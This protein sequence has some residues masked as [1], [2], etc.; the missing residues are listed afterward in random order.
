MIRRENHTLIFNVSPTTTMAIDRVIH[1][2][3]NNVPAVD[4]SLLVYMALN[5]LTINQTIS[6]KLTMNIEQLCRMHLST[7]SPEQHQSVITVCEQIA[8][9]LYAGYKSA[10]DTARFP[11]PAKMISATYSYGVVSMIFE[12]MD[13]KSCVWLYTTSPPS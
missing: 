6:A 1:T 11:M 3:L 2:R 4:I 13:D 9:L 7:Y 12:C 10:M 5:Q 8:G